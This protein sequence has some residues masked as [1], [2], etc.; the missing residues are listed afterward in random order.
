MKTHTYFVYIMATENNRVL[1]IGVTNDVCRRTSEH[2]NRINHGFTCKYNVDKLVYFEFF[3]YIEDAIL[4]EKQLKKW[5]REW[6]DN[7]IEKT[8]PNWMD[9][10]PLL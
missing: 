10:T 1:Y 4:R 8:N 2:K 7:L 6:K 9:L 3:K 5:N